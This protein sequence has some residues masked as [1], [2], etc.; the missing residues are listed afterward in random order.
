[1]KLG[2][3][4]SLLN[5]ASWLLLGTVLL[6]AGLAW[7]NWHYWAI[8]A[9]T[10]IVEYTARRLG[11]YQALYRMMEMPTSEYQRYRQAWQQT[12]QHKD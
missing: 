1:M 12:E 5:L 3:N 7:T 4:L 9:M 10:V 6:S 8:V 2:L 11:Q